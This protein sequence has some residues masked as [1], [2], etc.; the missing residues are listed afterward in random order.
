M[1]PAATAAV[2]LNIALTIVPIKYTII[3]HTKYTINVTTPIATG[4]AQ[5]ALW[6]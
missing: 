4:Y 3:A 5:N 6:R 1:L 2:A